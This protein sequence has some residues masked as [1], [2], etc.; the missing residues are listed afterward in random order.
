MYIYEVRNRIQ[1][2]VHVAEVQ[3]VELESLSGG[4]FFFDWSQE[5]NYTVLK[6]CRTDSGEILGL[7]S[8][9]LVPTEWI[10]RIRLLSVSKHNL[11]RHKKYDRIIGNLI[12]HVCNLAIEDFG[13]KACVILVPKTVLLSH[14]VEKYHFTRVGSLLCLTI[15]EMFKLIEEYDH[16]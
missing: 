14:Y 3:Q 4:E 11:G 9:E 8:V 16:D 12:T 13:E 5:Q 7:A 1:H 2:D 10:Y 15:S 6:L